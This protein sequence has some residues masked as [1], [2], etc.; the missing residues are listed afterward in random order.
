MYEEDTRAKF[1]TIRDTLRDCDYLALASNRLW[2]TIPR[3]PQRYPMST[4]YYEALFNGELGFEE[5]YSQA[6]PPRLGRLVLNDQDADESFTVY[7]HPRPIIFK[8]RRQLNDIEWET[9]LGDEWQGALHGYVGPPTLLTRLRGL[10]QSL[11]E[12]V[13]DPGSDSRKS[14]LLGRPVD[15]LPVVDDYHWN[16]LANRS[17]LGAIVIWWLAV[18]VIGWLAWPLTRRLFIRLPDRGYL[19]SKSLGWLLV[20]YGVW[21][22]SSLRLF[23]N[24]LPTI[25]AVLVGLGAT[26]G[27]LVLWGRRR[28]LATPAE[29][30]PYPLK[31][32]L[33]GEAIFILVYLFFVGLRLLN[34][35]LWQP[36]N[37][38]EKMLEIGFLNAI[39]K[40]AHMP[41]YDPYYAGGYINYYYYGLFLVGVLVKLTGIQP[42]IA[43]NLAVPMLA[44]HW[45][46]C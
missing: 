20:G 37:G 38:G 11:P 18:Q 22:V 10:G 33:L 19:L 4:R 44:G 30:T 25:I 1:E 28:R 16:P 35:D 21:L 26:S 27:L 39:V 3:L 2:R 7:D 24:A 12:T 43:F 36:W 5:V 34:P 29:G 8:K 9:L 13:S 42:A 31:L 40:S 45:P 15:E 46:C 17:T 32:I 23:P 6:T 14:L 41:P